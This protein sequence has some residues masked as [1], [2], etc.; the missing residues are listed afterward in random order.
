[1]AIEFL[2][3]ATLG[4]AHTVVWKDGGRLGGIYHPADGI[5][6]L[7]LG[8]SGKLG[9]AELSDPDLEQLKVKIRTRYG[10]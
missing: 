7:H 1:M 5:Y 8:D 9:P 4:E 3:A 2:R 10:P 6:R